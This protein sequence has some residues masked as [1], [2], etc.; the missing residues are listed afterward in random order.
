MKRL[1]C[2]SRRQSLRCL[3]AALAGGTSWPCLSQQGPRRPG[4]GVPVSRPDS[5]GATPT[6][7]SWPAAEL[8][9]ELR[10]GGYVLIFRHG[11]TDW[12]SRDQLPQTGFE[13]RSTQRLL[14]D[15]GREQARR[16]AE[17]FRALGVRFD[18]VFSSPYFRARDFAE[19]VTGRAPEV[20]RKLLGYD[21]IGLD[22]HRELLSRMPA[23]GTNTLLS[24]HQFAVTEL[25]FVRMNELE[26]GSCLIFKPTGD[27]QR[28]DMV[29]H[30]NHA[31]LLAL[32]AA[33]DK[34][35]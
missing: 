35:R 7:S 30:L 12:R 24:G 25:G 21:Q 33:L 26:E 20:T 34:P 27:R 17:V 13:D 10:S 31:D 14:S 16:T 4:D 9:K 8:A 3:V 29:A 15:E 11:R 6:W 2:V 23:P 18:A 28:L 19:L 32:P 5:Q 22:G 1:A